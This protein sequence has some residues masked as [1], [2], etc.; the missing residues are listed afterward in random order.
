MPT[1]LT[2]S[3]LSGNAPATLTASVGS[4]TAVTYTGHLTVTAS[5]AAQSPQTVTVTLTVAPASTGVLLLGTKT[6][7]AEH[8]SDANGQAE[9]FQATGAASGTTASIVLYLDSNSHGGQSD[10]WDLCG[11][12]RPSRDSARAGEH[13]GAKGRSL[14]HAY[15][16]FAD[17]RERPEV[18]V[19]HSGDGQR[20]D[21]LPRQAKRL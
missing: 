15:I 18:L 5:G 10:D 20:N 21:S 2:V 12:Q 14:E 13:L 16:P 1:W 17:D 8:D 9:A 11:R 7:G 3:P 6:L 19:R 4:L